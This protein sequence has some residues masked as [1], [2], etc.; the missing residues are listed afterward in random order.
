[1]NEMTSLPPRV[2]LK[3]SALEDAE[4]AALTLSTSTTRKIAE[5]QH[6]L[7]LNPNGPHADATRLEIERLEGLQKKYQD[8]HRQRADLNAK[9]RRFLAMLP[10]DT[11]LSD[12]RPIKLK[13]KDGE[14]HLDAVE[15]IRREIAGLASERLQVEQ[16]G[17]PPS[18][19]KK[20][21]K[22][23]IAERATRGRPTI[24]AT[25]DKF[26]VNF[27]DP[28]AYSMH[29]DIPS[30]LAWLDPQRMEARLIEQIEAMPKPKL[31]LTPS[32]K[33]DKLRELKQSILILE[34][35]EERIIVSAEEAGQTIARRGTASPSAILGLVV[36]RS[37]ANAA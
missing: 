27:L 33:A 20:R 24:T 10:A 8:Q 3:L 15:R 9:V 37:K 28:A 29:L 19:L 16:A 4:Q 18:E 25:H 5:L 31:A 1:M 11:E 2:H 23:W 14:T 21:V 17:L 36:D 32:E 7:A 6:A 22:E 12:A 35:Q 34:R 30:A 26:E 13:M